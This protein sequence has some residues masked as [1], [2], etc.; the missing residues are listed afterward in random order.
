MAEEQITISKKEYEKL[1]M[2]RDNYKKGLLS[3]KAKRKESKK[4]RGGKN[5]PE[6]STAWHGI[7]GSRAKN[8]LIL[9]LMSA[10]IKLLAKKDVGN[11]TYELRHWVRENLFVI[12]KK[13]NIKMAQQIIHIPEIAHFYN[14]ADAGI[15][16]DSIK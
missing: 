10:G 1:I 4:K 11:F 7:C 6:V 2:E 5:K 3:V 16:L 15:Y 13:D 14:E 12:Y 9:S 8:Y